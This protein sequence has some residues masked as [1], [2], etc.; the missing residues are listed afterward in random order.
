M[1]GES[2]LATALALL[3]VLLRRILFSEA[4]GNALLKLEG[5][6]GPAAEALGSHN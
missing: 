1:E 3:Q 6:A 5:T 2:C 4:N